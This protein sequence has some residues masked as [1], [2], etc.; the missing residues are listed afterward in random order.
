MHTTYKLVEPWGHH[1]CVNVR[2][3]AKVFG[4]VSLDGCVTFVTF[5][6]DLCFVAP[7]SFSRVWCVCVCVYHPHSGRVISCTVED[8]DQ[9]LEQAKNVLQEP[10]RLIVHD[11]THDIDEQGSKTGKS[12][13]RCVVSVTRCLFVV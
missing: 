4:N 9:K 1:V 7:F 13:L 3:Q 11:V 5:A 12:V 6:R 8:A 10:G 2:A